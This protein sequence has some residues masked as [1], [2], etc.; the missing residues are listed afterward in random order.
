MPVSVILINEN[1]FR[2][3]NSIES[4]KL[5][6]LRTNPLEVLYFGNCGKILKQK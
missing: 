4:I 3:Y 1:V 5:R 6:E 2:K